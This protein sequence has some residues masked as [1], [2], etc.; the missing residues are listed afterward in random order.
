M[1]DRLRLFSALGAWLGL[2]AGFVGLAF[3]VAETGPLFGALAPQALLLLPILLLL[4]AT[5]K[6]DGFRRLFL[7]RPRGGD[8]GLAMLMAICAAP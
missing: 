1:I 3:L 2:L 4:L 7:T 6:T 8:I 5:G